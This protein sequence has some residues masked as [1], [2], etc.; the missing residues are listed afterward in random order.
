MITIGE[1]KFFNQIKDDCK[2]IFDIG[3]RDD[4][5]FLSEKND[6]EIHL[7]EPNT[8]FYNSLLNE[9][10]KF[11]NTKVISNNFGL[12]SVSEEITYYHN[13]QSFTKLVTN[14]LSDTNNVSIF[15]VVDFKE[16]VSTNK[17]DKIDFIKIDTEGYEPEIIFSDIEF[18]KTNIKYLQFEYTSAWLSK[19]SVI[20]LETI[21]NDLSTYFNFY[22]LRDDQHPISNKFKDDLTLIDNNMFI[23]IDDYMKQGYGFN[24]GLIKKI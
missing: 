8:V 20:R 23:E 17:I 22:L 24:F 12:G 15:K 19:P 11:D 16:Y 13:T 21:Y 2:L 5:F 10:K 18:F 7:F 4:V 1:K 9:L 6:I 14:Y 3:A